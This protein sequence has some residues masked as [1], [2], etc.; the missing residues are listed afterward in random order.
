MTP[1]QTLEQPWKEVGQTDRLWIKSPQ[2]AVGLLK[3]GQNSDP[4]DLNY[5]KYQLPEKKFRVRS[6]LND[7]KLDPLP[8]LESLQTNGEIRLLSYKPESRLAIGKIGKYRSIFTKI[9]NPQRIPD[10][11]ERAKAFERRFEIH[12]MRLISAVQS[13][14]RID[15]EWIEARHLEAIEVSPELAIQLLGLDGERFP[16]KGFE[17]LYLSPQKIAQHLT[18][19]VAAYENWGALLLHNRLETLRPVLEHSK[20]LIGLLK[21]KEPKERPW[22]LHG[23]FRLK[24][25]LVDSTGVPRLC[26][27]DHLVLG[28]LEWDLAAWLADLEFCGSSQLASHSEAFAGLEWVEEDRLLLYQEAWAVL[29]RLKEME[30]SPE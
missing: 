25:V 27:A 9:Y 20:L 2:T 3:S 5:W 17:F 30:D 12:G 14:N 16:R 13:E 24:N 11:V 22:I 8:V 4:F 15:W 28:D 1:T 10:M 7:K 18:D 19:R 21:E 23:D 29:Y 6:I 26:D